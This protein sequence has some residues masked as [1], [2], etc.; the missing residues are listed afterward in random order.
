MKH[1]RL[2]MGFI[3]TALMGFL[4]GILVQAGRDAFGHTLLA[5]F[6][7]ISY[8]LFFWIA[9]CT[10][11]SYHAR[12]GLHAALLVLCLLIPTLFGYAL[13]AQ[14]LGIRLN[15]TV[16]IFGML[17]LLPSAIAAWILRAYRHRRAMRIFVCITGAAA[18]LFDIGA[19]GEFTPRALMLALPLL[20]YFIYTVSR[21]A[22]PHQARRY[23]QRVS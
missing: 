11:I 5:A 2:I 15:D 4:L 13:T 20:V 9:I 10:M 12:C 7:I 3:L 21:F 17:M 19:R 6:G 18:L 23:A 22:P 1:K 14:Y 8:G 16:M